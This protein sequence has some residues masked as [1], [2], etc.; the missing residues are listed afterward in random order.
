MGL[1]PCRA[2]L[3]KQPGRDLYTEALL[4]C[5]RG[6]QAAGQASHLTSPHPVWAARLAAQSDAGT[7]SVDGSVQRG[8]WWALRS[9]EASR[10]A[11]G[12]DRLVGLHCRRQ[13]V[14]RAVEAA[15][16]W[17]WWLN[18]G[19]WLLVCPFAFASC[20]LRPCLGYLLGG[21]A[22]ADGLHST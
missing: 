20:V 9:M 1:P 5:G 13:E 7:A 21:V 11:T 19:F 16:M 2:P 8:S 6:R 3:A 12:F 17:W 10:V 18:G 22:V 4:R 14:G 15:S